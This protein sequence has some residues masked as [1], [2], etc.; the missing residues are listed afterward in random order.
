MLFG[1]DTSGDRGYIQSRT[2]AGVNNQLQL[3][4]NGG[5][6]G[7]GTS[8]LSKLHVE[9]DICH[10]R[11]SWVWFS[12]QYTDND[13]YGQH[14]IYQTGGNLRFWW[15][16]TST[17]N[18]PITI[19]GPNGRVGIGTDNPGEK[20]EVDGAIRTTNNATTNE[21][22]LSMS[23]NPTTGQSLFQSKGKDDTSTGYYD[24][25][26]MEGDGGNQVQAMTIDTSGNVGIGVSSPAVKLDVN[27]DMNISG[28]ITQNSP[29]GIGSGTFTAT[30]NI[31]M[32]SC[33]MNALTEITQQF[34]RLMSY[35]KIG[36]I[37]NINGGYI[38]RYSGSGTVT[39]YISLTDIG[40]P[41]G[42]DTNVYVIT[43][44]GTGHFTN[45]VSTDTN[46]NRLIFTIGGLGGSGVYY[47]GFKM[48]MGCGYRTAY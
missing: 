6:V 40:L 45:T 44:N 32:G 12:N 16:N 14:G 15:R 9:G 26:V 36:N 38:F 29:N 1:C 13:S 5:N 19:D 8:P 7:I 35:T 41:T 48:L 22:G 46:N 39:T 2:I 37:I 25:V 10:P 42:T 43:N 11:E 33:Y 47:T 24:F 30:P 31:K 3:Q 20:L 23:Y 18:F 27:G 21:P 28:V 4:P 34:E 17:N